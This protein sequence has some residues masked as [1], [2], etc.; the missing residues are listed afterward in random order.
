MFN[1]DRPEEECGIIGIVSKDREFNAAS[2]IHIGLYA[3]Q[4]RGQESAG[5]A[6]YHDEYL[7]IKRGNGLLR[8]VFKPADFEN[9]RG[10]VG[11]GHV[12]YST[13][14]SGYAQNVQPI[15]SKCPAV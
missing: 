15:L 5:I 6:T 8:D 7:H 1:H 9:L 10:N 4:H 3:L 11:I 2:N 13:T 12:R 14:G